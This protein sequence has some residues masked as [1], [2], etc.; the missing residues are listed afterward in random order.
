M[1]QKDFIKLL[2]LKAECKEYVR[3]IS[4]NSKKYNSF[5]EWDTYIKSRL[6][7][8][9]ETIDI[10]NLK[11][12]CAHKIRLYNDT[13]Y[14]L[15]GYLGLSFPLTLMFSTESDRAGLLG[16]VLLLILMCFLVGVIKISRINAKEKYFYEDVLRLLDQI[17]SKI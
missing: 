1:Q 11:R 4:G 5:A 10:Y 13:S 6:L 8:R 2:D 14:I 9:E 12:Y 17:E 15:W 16:I 7:C 3:F